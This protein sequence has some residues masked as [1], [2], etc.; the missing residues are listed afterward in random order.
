MDSI[1][2]SVP[3]VVTTIA[4]S[5]AS[6]V[7]DGSGT[8]AAF[9]CAEAIAYSELSDSLLVAEDVSHHVRRVYPS[10]LT[11][12][13]RSDELKRLVIVSLY[14]SGALPIQAILLIISE[15]AIANST[16]R[17]ALISPLLAVPVP[18]FTTGNTEPSTFV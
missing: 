12:K 5:S 3:V 7:R 17:A 11:T 16:M 15:Y 6:A 1:I 10:S 4:G 8:S 9:T 13:H 14:E 18:L 2:I